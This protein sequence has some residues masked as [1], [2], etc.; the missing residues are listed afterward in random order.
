MLQ[1]Y[2]NTQ[3]FIDGEWRDSVSKETLENDQCFF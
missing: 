1:D 2:P 3:L